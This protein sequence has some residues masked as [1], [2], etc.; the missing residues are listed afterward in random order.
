MSVMYVRDAN[1]KFH[2]IRAIQG[3]PGNSGVHLGDNEPT[4]PNVKVW[5]NPNG[6]AESD[7]Y[8]LIEEIT[9]DSARNLWKGYHSDGTPYNYKKMRV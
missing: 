6:K 8:E 7:K 5:V 9:Q 2:P 1:G 3:A 4:D